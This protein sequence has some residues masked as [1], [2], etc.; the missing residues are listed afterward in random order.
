MSQLPY[1]LEGEALHRSFGGRKVLRGINVH[2]RAGEFVCLIGRSGAG[3]SVLLRILAGLDANFAGITSVSAPLGVVFQDARLLPWLR[4]GT[5]V[6]LGLSGTSAADTDAVL[7]EVGLPGRGHAWP[8]QLSV[9]EAQ[10]VALARTLIRRPEMLLLDEPFSALDAFTRLEMQ[11]LLHEVVSRRGAAALFVTHDLD[12]ALTLADRVLM[13]QGGEITH[14]VAVPEDPAD[15]DLAQLR[16]FLLGQL[17]S[18]TADRIA[19]G[20]RGVAPPSLL[21]RRREL[22]AGQPA[23]G[24]RE[25]GP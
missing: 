10:R 12:E 8:R 21:K 5:N 9:G 3:K 1:L 20:S 16:A 7:A 17:I 24:M 4:V 13:L 15:E 2:V 6:T 11:Q 19:V 25:E 14:D 18:P 22:R 23:A